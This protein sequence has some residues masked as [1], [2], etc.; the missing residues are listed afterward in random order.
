[1][2]ATHANREAHG[3]MRLEALGRDRARIETGDGALEL[4][5]RHSEI[6]VVL[7]LEDGPTDAEH[8]AR[9]IYGEHG[10]PVTARA[11]VSRLRQIIGEW[12]P[13]GELQLAGPVDA[14]FLVV[15]G[16]MRDGRLHD[17]LER[18]RGPL[19][20][21]SRVALLVE[22]RERLDQAFATRRC[23]LRIGGRCAIWLETPSG[24]DDV[25][26]CRA[27]ISRLGPEA[28]PGCAC[29]LLSRLRRL[30]GAR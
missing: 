12:L 16:L 2:P 26:A 5:R 15:E 18:Y 11:E 4:S 27:L 10:N 30:T 22:A 19:L 1:M 7:A 25:V 21:G 14:D 13:R 17:A 20:P 8:L 9:V 3:R 28:D 29:G 6:L 24:R 23:A